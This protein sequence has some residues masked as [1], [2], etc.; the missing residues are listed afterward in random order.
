MNNKEQQENTQNLGFYEQESKL[1]YFHLRLFRYY[2]LYTTEEERQ[3]QKNTDILFFEFQDGRFSI[4][5]EDLCQKATQDSEI[6][7][8]NTAYNSYYNQKN[9]YELKMPEIKL[10]KV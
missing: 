7:K 5:Y 1:P 10:K 2:Y 6:L 3:Q 9:K 4:K 8:T